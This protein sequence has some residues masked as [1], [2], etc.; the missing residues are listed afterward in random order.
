MIFEIDVLM[1]FNV[2][3]FLLSNQFLKKKN[4]RSLQF[5]YHFVYLFC[6]LI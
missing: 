5:N 1:R 4:I 6:N 2:F 3:A